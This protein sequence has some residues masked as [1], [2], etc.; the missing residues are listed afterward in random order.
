VAA[1]ERIIAESEHGRAIL[2]AREATYPSAVSAA[3]LR[4]QGASFAQA[5]VCCRFLIECAA[6]QPPTGS[7]PWSLRRYDRL[8]ALCAVML[9]WAYLDDAYEYE[10]SDND[11]L[12]NSDGEL[13]L[14]ELDRY[15][16]GRSSFY[17]QYLEGQRRLA[18][19]VFGL[20]F[21]RD[22]VDEPSPIL[23]R[24]D[25]AMDGEA[26]VS[27]TELRELLHAANAHARVLGA[28]AVAVDRADAIRDLA[29]LLEWDDEKVDKG[30]AYLTMGARAELLKPPTGTVLDVIPSRFARRWSLNRR[31]F[32]ARGDQLVWGRRQV[33]AA[34][35]VIFTQVFS[36][37]FQALAETAELR[38]VVGAI[39]S[40]SGRAFEGEVADRI[41]GHVDVVRRSV[42]TINKR[43]IVRENGEDLGDIDVLSAD[44]ANKLVFAMEVKDLAGALT[45]TEVAGELKAHFDVVP[46]TSSSKH[47][48]R[49]D[50]L[51]AHLPDVLAELDIA[52]D[53]TGWRVLG[54]FVTSTTVMAPHIKDTDFDIVSVHS[55]LAWLDDQ[56]TAAS[57]RHRD[58]RR[59]KRGRRGRGKR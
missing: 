36:G 37:R 3:R 54:V 22:G 12:I 55:V 2:P 32:I 14:V 39:A 20:R 30:V 7:E 10:M 4:E 18:S 40:E 11:V 44:R 35:R 33:L 19:D 26:G 57:R 38:D 50:W 6:A 5:G 56:R 28:D 47:R 24:V 34:L 43:K 27:L 46:G 41:D 25:P 17:D 45:P 59:G 13:R 42:K 52:D 49:T 23:A 16:R 48:E 1:N 21:G 53:P 8:M 29:E 15:E 31:P 51:T 58:Q 9:D